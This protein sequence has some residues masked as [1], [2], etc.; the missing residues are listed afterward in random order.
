[1]P[2]VAQAVVLTLTGNNKAANQARKAAV[3]SAHRGERKL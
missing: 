1:M 3:Q 2:E